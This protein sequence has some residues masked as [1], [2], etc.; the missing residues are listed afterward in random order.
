MGLLTVMK[1]FPAYN[2]DMQEDK[3]GVFDTVD[4]VKGC[5][6]VFVPMLTTLK[7]NKGR[8]Y[9]AA[10]EGFSNAT[11][12]AD[13]LVKKGVPFRTAHRIVGELVLG[14]CD[15]GLSLGQL[16]IEDYRRVSPVFQEDILEVIK[17]ENCVAARNI[18][19]GPAP[20]QVKAH[21]QKSRDFLSRFS[22]S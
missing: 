16:T 2:K 3:E 21:I 14:C 19:G 10:G 17:P 7:F 4:T 12:V 18:P 8:M 5:L 20:E 9:Q 11:D 1:G 22:K 15:K 6:S 13:Y